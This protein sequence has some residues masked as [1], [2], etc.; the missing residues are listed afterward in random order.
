MI[1]CVASI[2]CL[3]Y[4]LILHIQQISIV[5]VVKILNQFHLNGGAKICIRPQALNSSMQFAPEGLICKSTKTAL[6]NKVL[7]AF[8][9]QVVRPIKTYSSR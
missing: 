4:T 1:G 9:R 3:Q 7:Q 8:K 5:M 6:T 2:I